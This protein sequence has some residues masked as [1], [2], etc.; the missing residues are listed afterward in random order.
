[1]PWCVKIIRLFVDSFELLGDFGDGA[2]PFTPLGHFRPYTPDAMPTLLPN[3]GYATA[4]DL[5]RADSRRTKLTC[6]K[7]TQLHDAL[8]VTR[9]SVTKLIGCRAAVRALLFVKS[10]REL[11]FSS[12]QFVC[13]EHGFTYLTTRFRRIPV[14]TAQFPFI[15]TNF[16]DWLTSDMRI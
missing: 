13:C 8:L 3:P 5:S 6:T 10:V 12:V 14:P 2:P 11:Q 15:D 1:M 16:A 4:V 7:L 9:V